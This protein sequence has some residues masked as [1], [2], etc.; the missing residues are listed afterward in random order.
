MTGRLER[1]LAWSS[2]VVVL[3]GLAGGLVLLPVVQPEESIPTRLLAIAL[4]AIGAIAVRKREGRVIGW[5][6]IAAGVS[7]ATLDVTYSYA[8]LWTAA[9][10]DWPRGDWAHLVAELAGQVSVVPMFIFLPLLFPTGRVASPGWAWVLR[11]S[12]GLAVIS[13][14]AI[15]FGPAEYDDES[16]AVVGTNPLGI[17]APDT[18]ELIATVAG[19]GL[20]AV[21]IVA[22]GGFIRRFRRSAGTERLQMR[23]L[24]AGF[25]SAALVMLSMFAVAGLDMLTGGIIGVPELLLDLAM[26]VAV[27]FIPFGAGIAVTRYR[28]YEID[29]I[30]SRTATYA[31]VVAVLAAVYAAA[32][33][34]FGSIAQALFG[35]A[36]NDLVV[37]VSTLLV[38]A[39]FQPVQARVRERIDR[40]FNRHRYDA[41]REVEAF[42]G[43]LRDRVALDEVVSETCGA[44]GR[45]VQPAGI[46][47]WVR[48]GGSR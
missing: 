39:A 5:L 3:V 48:P 1:T 16:G 21:A 9:P 33:V 36:S 46:S 18:M 20:L 27:L 15:L 30:V 28:L 6:M 24:A 44:A 2:L 22:V 17:G 45:T 34:G 35:D 13:F 26:G 32:V 38:A 29:R 42:G 10:G 41:R 40:R 25:A 12:V 7:S 14:L 37:A 43:R 23:W 11:T 8:E 4:T 47:L 19:L 31:V